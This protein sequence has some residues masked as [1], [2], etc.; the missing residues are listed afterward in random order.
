MTFLYADGS[1]HSGFNENSLVTRLDLGARRV[2]LMGDAE[3]GG[4]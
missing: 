3:A 1:H 2:L 4:R